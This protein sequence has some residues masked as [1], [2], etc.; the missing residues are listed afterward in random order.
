MAEPIILKITAK[1]DASA[2]VRK[3]RT[4]LG[5]L[6]DGLSKPQSTPGSGLPGIVKGLGPALA[7]LGIAAAAREVA[8][9]SKASLE[10]AS[11][12]NNL[13]GGLAFVEGSAEAA[14]KRFGEFLELAK[15]PGL[16][17]ATLTRYD[18]ILKT[19]G[20]TAEE[21]DRIFTGL[22]K[23][24]TTFGGGVVQVKS[25][26]FQFAQAAQKGKADAQDLKSIIEQTNGQF[27]VAAKKIYN[28]NGGAQVLNKVM[29]DSGKTFGEFYAPI[30][31]KMAELPGAEIDSYAN[32]VDNLG[33]AMQQLQAA[34]GDK[35]LPTAR[36]WLTWLID[37]TEKTTD[38]I[39]GTSDLEKKNEELVNSFAK[40]TALEARLDL[41]NNIETQSVLL[42]KVLGSLQTALTFSGSDT[43]RQTAGQDLGELIGKTLELTTTLESLKQK[44]AGLSEQDKVTTRTGRELKD[45]IEGLEEQIADNNAVITIGK[46]VFKDYAA[47][48][49]ITKKETKDTT[50]A[51][52]ELGTEAK[53]TEVKVKSYSESIKDLK[54]NVEDAAE[55]QRQWEE[56]STFFDAVSKGADTFA[57]T[58]E[59]VLIPAINDLD[60]DHA[61]MAKAVQ[62]DL[63]GM[64]ADLD[65]V[66]NRYRNILILEGKVGNFT[67][68]SGTRPTGDFTQ[69]RAFQPTPVG[70][71]TAGRRTHVQNP[72]SGLSGEVRELGDSFS[73]ATPKVREFEDVSDISTDT[74]DD[75]NANVKNSAE[76]LKELNRKELAEFGSKIHSVVDALDTLTPAL[77]GFGL[78]LT[79]QRS[80][81][82]LAVNTLEGVGKFASGDV[83]GGITGIIASMWEWGQPD[84]EELKKQHEAAL[85]REKQ[86]VEKIQ[87]S[88]DAY[89]RDRERLFKDRLQVLKSDSDNFDDWTDTLKSF[90]DHDLEKT[91]ETFE[92]FT[93]R[94]NDLNDEINEARLAAKPLASSNR[95]NLHQ[96]LKQKNHPQGPRTTREEADAVA[97]ASGMTTPE[98]IATGTRIENIGNIVR[99]LQLKSTDAIGTFNEAINAP[100]RTIESVSQ[101]MVDLKPI[102]RELYDGLVTQIAGPDGIINTAEERLQ[103][104]EL[105]TF[106]EYIEPYETL[107]TNAIAAIN[108]GKQQLETTKAQIAS[109][110]GMSAFKEAVKAPG[111]TVESINEAW[112]THV[113]PTLDRLYD[114]LFAAIAG[115]DGFINT[116][117]ELIAYNLLG[118]RE[119]WKTDIRQGNLDPEV[120]QAIAKAEAL[121]E[122]ANDAELDRNLS[123]ATANLQEMVKDFAS[124]EELKAYWNTEVVPVVKL[125]YA[126]LVEGL[127]SQGHSAAQ[128]AQILGAANESEWIVLQETA[129]LQ[130]EI[131]ATIA[132]FENIAEQVSDQKISNDI[133]SATTTLQNMAKDGASIEELNT[134]WN[135]V[136][137]PAWTLFYEDLVK[138]L[139]EQGWTLEQ[140]ES[141]YGTLPDFLFVKQSG[142]LTPLADGIIEKSKALAETIDDAKI[143]KDITDATTT[144]NQM[145]EDGASIEELNTHWNTVFVPAWTRFYEDLVDDLLAANWT[146]EDIEAIHGTLPVFL[147]VKEAGTIQPL[148]DGIIEKGEN[149]AETVDDMTRNN[150]IGNATTTLDQMVKDGASIADVN[151]YWNTEFIPLIDA[152][153][154]DIV[155]QY[156]EADWTLEQIEQVFGTKTEYRANRRTEITGGHIQS[157]AEDTESKAETVSDT[158]RDNDLSAELTE[159]ENLLETG[160]S[161]A[162]LIDHYNTNILPLIDAAYDDLVDDLLKAGYTLEQIQAMHGTRE[163][164]RAKNRGEILTP[165][166]QKTSTPTLGMDQAEFNLGEATDEADFETKRNLWIQAINAYY[167]AE[168]E[169]IDNLEVS[170]AELRA[171]RADNQ[172]AR[173]QALQGATHATNQFAEERLR[174]EEK[175]Q[176]NIEDLRDQQVDNEQDRLAEIEDAN[177]DHQEKLTDIEEKGIRDRE[178]LYLT[179]QEKVE[180]ARREHEEDILDL[181]RKLTAG[182]IS[183]EEHDKLFQESQSKMFDAFSDAEFERQRQLRRQ[184]IQEERAIEEAGTDRE[185]KIQDINMQAEATAT[186]LSETLATA[187]SE[188]NIGANPE[189]VQAQTDAAEEQKGAAEEQKGAAVVSKEASTDMK[190]AAGEQKGAAT[191]LKSAA[192]VQGLTAAAAK[193]SESANSLNSAAIALGI[194]GSFFKGLFDDLE[195]DKVKGIPIEDAKAIISEGIVSPTLPG[196]TS[197][198]PIE[199]K[200]TNPDDMYDTEKIKELRAQGLNN[201][202][203]G[204]ELRKATQEVK[205]ET[206]PEPEPVPTPEPEVIVLEAHPTVVEEPAPTPE[207]AQISGSSVESMSVSAGSVYLSGNIAGTGDEKASAAEGSPN[208]GVPPVD[209]PFH[210]R[211]ADKIARAQGQEFGGEVKRLLSGASPD[212]LR[213]AKD[214]SRE[215]RGGAEEELNEI[216]RHLSPYID[217]PQRTARIGK[218]MHRSKQQVSKETVQVI[219]EMSN[220]DVA[221]AVEKAAAVISR[222]DTGGSGSPSTPTHQTPR[223]TVLNAVIH[224]HTKI[225]DTET[226][227]IS[228]RQSELKEHGFNFTNE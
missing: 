106:E 51:T 182:E 85:A 99:S 23:G 119:D 128:I 144:L 169:R 66:I 76:E 45:E 31:D 163:T 29:K 200:V 164:Y 78:D 210:F 115:P 162:K 6:D 151:E 75:F 25:A 176:A 52:E 161:I 192:R 62:A 28:F 105:G 87:A 137:V 226:V 134:H 199:V 167:D 70:P 83:V 79:S 58:I 224:T 168:E 141:V 14:E 132:H 88:L 153:Y 118:S 117:E 21:N 50:G 116:T 147:G 77:E 202:E 136:F 121:A 22:S 145:A 149:V 9:F 3:I 74:L 122:S 187:L 196:E 39:K 189:L 216:V 65:G 94:M 131:D 197:G 178:D 33:D 193:L 80:H 111:A 8:Q 177:R 222:L 174:T 44:Y 41:L 2:V 71:N 203:I 101:A 89:E 140:I 48:I 186:Q 125:K 24:V 42:T 195:D 56:F 35:L 81:G 103:L 19:V 171:L 155:Q 7:G 43:A 156:L 223:P 34:I 172:L 185:E 208:T 15:N 190:V 130:P 205:V 160:A 102:L 12:M 27:L 68:I 100:L 10:A 67:D 180:E 221:Q 228:R 207:P 96:T 123:N 37:A 59:D 211:E 158:I 36:E 69:S 139:I 148:T 212:H 40:N 133:S 179:F 104:E 16:D 49:R 218:M 47:G 57:K 129:T 152:E 60:D 220:K 184:S 109:D 142:V 219:Y 84:P 183:Q 90:S 114:V 227:E 112:T 55:A 113:E 124:V 91:K 4:E 107:E 108:E 191:E 17:L 188:L 61:A 120:E 146:L 38:F 166:L 54:K 214:L 95:Y 204:R 1:D 194:V 32:K 11:D 53:D 175:L 154:A 198:E 13:K 206:E 86:R 215:F 126:D 5:K 150:A 110:D 93:E 170:E 30:F 217:T 201:R 138:G 225:G 165:T 181:G 82:R 20:F 173:E 98:E 46:S 64:Q 73:D 72:L 18:S 26:L 213:S 135:T 63:E 127:E 209:A 92:A 97:L 157:I 143:S 159:L